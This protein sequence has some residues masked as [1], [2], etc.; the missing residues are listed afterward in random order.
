MNTPHELKTAFFL[1]PIKWASTHPDPT[2]AI[3]LWMKTAP[4]RLQQME[5]EGMMDMALG[6]GVYLQDS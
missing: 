1:D 3:L 2:P 4:A 5:L 6:N